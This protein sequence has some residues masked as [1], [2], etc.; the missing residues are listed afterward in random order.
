MKA[1]GRY[2]SS[3]MI[4]VHDYPLRAFLLAELMQHASG[5]LCNTEGGGVLT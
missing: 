1:G 5:S 2:N 3:S 4:E